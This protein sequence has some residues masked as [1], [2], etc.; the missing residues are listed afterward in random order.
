MMDDRDVDVEKMEVK[1]R[2]QRLSCNRLAVHS[3]C[4]HI[5]PYGFG[6]HWT[7]FEIPRIQWRSIWQKSRMDQ[8]RFPSWL[9][10]NYPL[11]WC[12]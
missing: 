2:Y 6:K 10:L 8:N 4:G 7:R 3:R 11:R 5:L 12:I 9:D 1:L